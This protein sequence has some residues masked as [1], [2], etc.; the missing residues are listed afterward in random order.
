MPLVQQALLEQLRERPP[1]ALNVALV[2]GDVGV[3]EI[4]P[5]ADTVRHPLP[6]GRVAED[7][8]H[9]A[10]NEALDAVFLNGRF[11][12]DAKFLLDLDLDRQPVR[13][14][15]RFSRDVVAAHRAVA[16]KD[17]FEDASQNMAVVRQPVGGG[18]A[19][20]EGKRGPSAAVLEAL[21]E[22]A[23]LAPELLNRGLDLREVHDRLGLLKLRFVHVRLL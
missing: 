21:L 5:E 6:L 4:D 7:R 1:N 14:P 3:G 9:A 16:Q 15:A 22:D 2:I 13:V 17:V 18:R 20:V 10:K 11:A 23:V 8:L 19:L 12:V